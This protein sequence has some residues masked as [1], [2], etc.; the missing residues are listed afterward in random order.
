MHRQDEEDL[1]STEAQGLLQSPA[2]CPSLTRSLL[3]SRLCHMQ[4]RLQE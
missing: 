2:E 4:V 1:T 3:L